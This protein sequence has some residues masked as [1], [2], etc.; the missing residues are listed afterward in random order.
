MISTCLCIADPA[1]F[2]ESRRAE[3]LVVSTYPRGAEAAKDLC[4]LVRV[5]GVGFNQHD[6][7]FRLNVIAYASMASSGRQWSESRP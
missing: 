5:A 4:G 1:Y 3:Q 6:L 7:P 2:R